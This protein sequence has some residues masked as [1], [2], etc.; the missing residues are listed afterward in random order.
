MA[1]SSFVTS[2]FPVAETKDGP[3]EAV[4]VA[5]VPAEGAVSIIAALRRRLIGR[6]EGSVGSSEKS[7]SESEDGG[8][9]AF[10]RTVDFLG[11]RRLKVTVA[12]GGVRIVSFVVVSI[13]VGAGAVAEHSEPSAV[14][15]AIV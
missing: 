12:V 1:S 2:A 10:F 3:R 7:E 11:A 8:G 4:G 13:L 9:V 5:R 14:E 6:E 15:S